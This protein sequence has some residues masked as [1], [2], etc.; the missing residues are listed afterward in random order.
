MPYNAPPP[1]KNRKEVCADWVYSILE[2]SPEKTVAFT[3]LVKLGDNA[4]YTRGTIY[5]TRDLLG[6]RV[7]FSGTGN[8]VYWSIPK[9]DETTMKKIMGSNGRVKHG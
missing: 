1:K 7:M 5:A 8:K 9:K 2:A 6:D 3:E 4:G